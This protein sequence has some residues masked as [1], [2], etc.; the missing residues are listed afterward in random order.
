MRSRSVPSHHG[1]PVKENQILCSNASARF[2]S[3]LNHTRNKFA[4]KVM[5][6]FV[7]MFNGQG[8]GMIIAKT[9]LLL[10]QEVGFGEIK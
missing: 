5:E 10:I 1:Q 6:V 9:V 2:S 7:L 3:L 4:F 8:C